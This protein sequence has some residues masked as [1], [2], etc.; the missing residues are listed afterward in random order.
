M[1]ADACTND[2]GA[3]LT[4]WYAYGA[5]VHAPAA[6]CIVAAVGDVEDTRP[7]D[8]GALDHDERMQAIFG[9]YVIIDHGNGQFSLPGHL[10][11]GTLMFTAGQNL[12]GEETMGRVGFSGDTDLAHLHHQ[13]QD[14]PDRYTAEGLP[15]RFSLTD[16]T[17]PRPLAAGSWLDRLC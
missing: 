12:L 2:A 15:T 3:I 4:D 16:N 11:A 7:G 1:S 17:P 5:D 13:L 6:G 10:L 14:G 9:N 8:Y